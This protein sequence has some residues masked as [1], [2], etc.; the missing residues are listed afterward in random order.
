[1]LLKVLIVD[2]EPIARKGIRRL[3]EKEPDI[4]IIGECSDG[5]EA[6]ERI[7]DKKPDI[8]FLDIQMPELDGF[9]V[10]EAL[11]PSQIPVIIFIT[12]FDEF[13]LKAFEVHALD[14]LLKPVKAEKF[15]HAIQRARAILQFKQTDQ[16]RKQLESMVNYVSAKKQYVERLIVK[17][18]KG[19]LIVP[20]TDVDWFE[21]YG[22]YIRLHTKGKK[23][24]IRKTMNE[25]DE[26]LNPE[27]F[28]RIHRS[29]I[30]QISRVKKLQ[31]LNNGDY[32]TFLED[33]TQ[34][35]LSR[36]YSKFFLEKIGGSM[37]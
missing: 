26:S 34:L 9:G 17:D 23:H 12:A 11:E 30:V 10:L 15:Q 2:D 6:V 35:S 37:N 32:V 5:L 25:M 36:T 20:A 16:L 31:P 8:V 4:E 14:Y 29:A 24:L 7:N 22:D 27:F 33:G 28:A 21:A 3:L 1:M 13:A 18:V 19:I